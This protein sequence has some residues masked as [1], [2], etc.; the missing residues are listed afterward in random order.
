MAGLPA[1]SDSSKVRSGQVG[2]ARQQLDAAVI[3]E[4]DDVWRAR[5]TEQLG[6]ADY[7]AMIATLE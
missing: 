6:F 3:A 5:I 7:A 1:D 4:L 2:G